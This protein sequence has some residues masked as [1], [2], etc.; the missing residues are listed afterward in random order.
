ML[1]TASLTRLSPP[2]LFLFLFSQCRLSYKDSAAKALEDLKRKEHDLVELKSQKDIWENRCFKL[3]EYMRKL[4]SKCEE[5][6]T[7]YAQQ[8]TLL[9]SL[10]TKYE[11]SKAKAKELARKYA[12]LMDD[13]QANKEVGLASC[14]LL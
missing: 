8:S 2:V 7:S 12:Q 10:H 6:E 5:W 1:R 9:E 11:K 4:T 3:R 14:A 13:V